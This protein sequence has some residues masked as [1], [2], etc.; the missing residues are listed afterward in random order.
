MERKMMTSKQITRIALFSALAFVLRMAF[1]QL[2]NIQP[3]T[4]L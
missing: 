3:V 2:P 4:A 1:S